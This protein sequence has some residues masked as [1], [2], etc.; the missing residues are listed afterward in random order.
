[1][2]RILFTDFALCFL[3]STNAGWAS[4]VSHCTPAEGCAGQ[5]LT[6]HVCVHKLFLPLKLLHTAMLAGG[7]EFLCSKPQGCFCFQ[8]DKT[9]GEGTQSRSAVD[10]EPTVVLPVPTH[11]REV[12][13]EPL[14]DPV[15]PSPALQRFS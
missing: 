13:E 14:L 5:R 9:C 6:T 10:P 1:M 8:V 15:P 4:S 3:H 7:F 11:P 2:L 12:W